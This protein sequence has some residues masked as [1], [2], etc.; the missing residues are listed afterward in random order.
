MLKTPM[1]FAMCVPPESSSAEQPPDQVGSTALGCVM[2]AQA[3]EP[4]K[5]RAQWAGGHAV[6]TNFNQ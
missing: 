3:T 6:R 2:P 5:D 4:P 1:V